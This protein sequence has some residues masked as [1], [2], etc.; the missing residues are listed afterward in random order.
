MKLHQFA[1]TSL[2]VLALSA[3]IVA[4]TLPTSAFAADTSPIPHK[5]QAPRPPKP[6]EIPR[7]PDDN[8]ILPDVS[9]TTIGHSG[10]PF[11][12]TF[13]TIEFDLKTVNANAD[14]INLTG[15]CTYGSKY[16]FTTKRNEAI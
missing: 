16:D 4:T 1:R 13:T 11:L 3:G 15:G 8:Q 2:A 12:D 10:D 7:T 9:V 6:P 14:G 5:P